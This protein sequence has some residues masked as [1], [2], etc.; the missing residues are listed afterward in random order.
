MTGIIENKE[1]DSVVFAQ[2]DE[3]SMKNEVT[4]RKLRQA[5]ELL[6]TAIEPS[7]I[8]QITTCTSAYEV[9]E[10]LESIFQRRSD[11][12]LDTMLNRFWSIKMGETEPMAKYIGRIQQLSDTIKLAGEPLSDRSIKVRMISGLTSRYEGFSRT[13]DATHPDEKSVKHLID[14]LL[15]D[16]DTY[17]RRNDSELSSALYTSRDR[18]V[19][20]PPG[21][22]RH[23]PEPQTNQYNN[24]TNPSCQVCG[25]RNHTTSNCFF[26]NKKEGQ[27]E[28]QALSDKTK[29]VSFMAKSSNNKTAKWFADSGASNHMCGDRSTFSEL[30]LFQNAKHITVGNTEEI[31]ALG[32]GTII[33]RSELSDGTSRK[34]CLKKVLYVPNIAE[35]LLSIGAATM[36][37]L[38]A[39]FRGK[40][41]K[42]MAQEEE[43]AVGRRNDQNCLY[44]MDIA[45]I[46]EQ[47]KSNHYVTTEALLMKR[48][49]PMAEWHKCLGHINTK[50]IQ[51]LKANKSV[52]GMDIMDDNATV[53]CP[54]CA[55][56]KAVHAS[57]PSSSRTKASEVGKIVHADL[58]GPYDASVG[59]N[60]YAL[61]LTDEASNFMTVYTIQSKE[62]VSSKLEEF[63]ATIECDTGNK[64]RSIWSDCGTEFLNQKV[65]TLINLEHATLHTSS[66]RTPQQNGK[67][68]RS[69][70][71]I[72]EAA[73]TMLIASELPAKL[74]CEALK[75]AAYLLNCTSKADC[76]NII[77][78]EAW[79]GRK[80]CL[81]NLAEFGKEIH[82][83]IDPRKITK[84]S[85]KTRPAYLIGFTRRQ[86]TYRTYV[87]RD[88][89]IHI[90]SDVIFESHKE[91]TNVEEDSS[92]NNLEFTTTTST[93]FLDV[94][95]G[96]TD[97]G[98]PNEGEQNMNNDEDST[99]DQR[100]ESQAESI[101]RTNNDDSLSQSE[102]IMDSTY[103]VNEIQPSVAAF[104]PATDSPRHSSLAQD[105]RR[106]TEN[107]QDILRPGTR[108]AL[109]MTESEP[110]S[111][112]EAINS[113]ERDKWLEAIK[114]EI[115][116]LETNQ[117][118]EISDL[119]STK[120][121]VSSKWLF[122]KKINPDGKIDKYK[123]RVVARGFSQK[124]GIDYL[125]TY[126]SVVRHE[127]IRVFF[128]IVIQMRLDYVQYDVATAFLNG[129]L[130]D[131]VYLTPPEGIKCPDNKVL[132]L[133]KSI[134]GLRQSPRCWQTKLNNIL[135][136]V[137]LVATTSDPSL[138]TGQ[139]NNTKVI[140]IVYV[141]DG[142]AA[143]NNKQ[144]LI[145]IIH[146]IGQQIKIK[147]VD[148]DCFVG[149]E[150]NRI[151]S[152]TIT[153]H[154]QSFIRQTLT[155]Y[156]MADCKPTPT[157]ITDTDAL[158]VASEHDET[159]NAPYRELVGSL[160]YISCLTCPDISF[161]VN[162]LAKFCS[163][164]KTKHWTALKHILRYL[165]ATQSMGITYR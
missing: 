156:N 86:N 51:E 53:D 128:A 55:R 81:A 52:E 26:R 84:W 74:W 33:F 120:S 62:N 95:P 19:R 36:H 150:I 155:K 85:P 165:R 127:T 164:L 109:L 56:G 92:E 93:S 57:H 69:N 22:F 153:L 66:P 83:L 41:C 141:D 132:K 125:E 25:K 4:K 49:R 102:R 130:E 103:T 45:P 48:K 91:A 5:R 117:T 63:F 148:N 75:T 35:N 67:A 82:I 17:T 79:Y 10:R 140:M 121:P 152:S 46:V 161:A 135:S 38:S 106:R 37:Q 77:S 29:V 65:Q 114:I 54:D 27:T 129:T 34:I 15:K 100:S 163:C 118:W 108:R 145:D 138:Y 58:M 116:A 59:G 115:D 23:R 98:V 9:W 8:D 2:P 136:H 42:L 14:R 87:P 159:T 137:G 122:K 30:K 160:N 99:A 143:A 144:T 61:L 110:K 73:K 88:E 24:R 12:N 71:T 105:W 76:S 89:S 72:K 6:T 32:E 68:E 60:R 50:R 146:K 126:A 70:R 107:I 119:P 28:R 90:T 31:E 47:V 43:V 7:I 40:I 101:M 78:Y 21:S 113:L 111:Y 123:A 64:S 154:Q 16:E 97:Q 124:F 94:D 18:H 134:Y 142:I 3:E 80:P 133:R 147:I 139:Y 96:D 20:A 131:E 11:C 39:T 112:D 157:P 44:E 13:W 149:F 158:L 1:L 104:I 162:L 151:N